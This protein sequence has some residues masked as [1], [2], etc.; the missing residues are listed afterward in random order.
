MA[1][2]I[3]FKCLRVGSDY[4]KVN[5]LNGNV[6][7]EGEVNG[8]EIEFVFDITTAIKFSKTIRTEINKAKEVDNV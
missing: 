5:N 1:I 6:W 4:L 7:I 2:E 8:Q 3:K